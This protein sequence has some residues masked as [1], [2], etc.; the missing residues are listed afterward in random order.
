MGVEDFDLDA[1]PEE[2]NPNLDAFP[3]E[4]VLREPV[5]APQLPATERL[6][7]PALGPDVSRRGTGLGLV[8]FAFFVFAAL[9]WGTN[10]YIRSRTLT[11]ETH[12]QAAVPL[13]PAN[14]GRTDPSDD[15][16]SVPPSAAPARTPEP[17]IPSTSA[18]NV[19][20]TWA[21]TTRVRTSNYPPYHGLRLGYRIRLQQ[22]GERVQGSGA[23]ITENGGAIRPRGQTPIFLAGTIDGDRLSLTF[24]ESGARRRTQG[25]FV[26]L[27]DERDTLRGRFSSTAAQSSGTVEAHRLRE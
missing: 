18:N 19:S 10:R 24:D 9:G 26:L 17:V 13:R 7:L 5:P 1:F 12:A 6:A 27:L 23:K 14:Q 3:E 16:A 11:Q 21:V 25:K 22:D 15:R 20:G 8:L 4:R 2:G